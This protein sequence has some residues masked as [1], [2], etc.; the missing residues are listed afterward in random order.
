[1]LAQ[2]N[3]VHKRADSG[4]DAE[5]DSSGGR[6][7]YASPGLSIALPGKTQAY[8]FYQ[9]PLYR[10]VTGIQLTANRALVLGISGQL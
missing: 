7:L 1:M 5:P 9:V 3:Y 8:L 10:H 6:Y 4:S 2:L